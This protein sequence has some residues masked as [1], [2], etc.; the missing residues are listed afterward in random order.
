MVPAGTWTMPVSV[1]AANNGHELQLTAPPMRCR[2]R[3]LRV[4]TGGNP[5]RIQPCRSGRRAAPRRA[6]P[7]A[8]QHIESYRILTVGGKESVMRNGTSSPVGS[9]RG[10]PPRPR[11]SPRP[12]PC[13]GHPAGRKYQRFRGF[14]GRFWAAASGNFAHSAL[15]PGTRSS[16]CRA[17]HGA[18]MQL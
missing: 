15:P 13:C 8:Q 3:V 7:D 18:R 14:D 17:L 2:T 16:P 6:L 12:W 10:A 1:A 9:P 4:Q 11:G 5:A